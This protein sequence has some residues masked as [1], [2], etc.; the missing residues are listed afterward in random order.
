[1]RRNR[2]VAVLAAVSLLVAVVSLSSRGGGSRTQGAANVVVT[3]RLARLVPA[4]MVV[5]GARPAL[6]WPVQG[7]GAVAVQGIGLMGASSR[8]PIVPIASLTKMMTAYVVLHDHPLAPGEPGPKLVMGPHDVAAYAADVAANNSSVPVRLGERL[9]E[10][11]LLEALLVPSADNIAD[12]LGAW[13]AGSDAAFVVKMNATAR[14]L[15]L[16][17]THYADASGLDPRSR[18]TAADQARLA[19][20][21]MRLPVVRSIVANPSLPFPVAGRVTN[22]NPA[23]GTDG[24]V[25]VKSG[26]TPQAQG[27]LATAAYRVVGGRTV[28]VVAVSLDQ[29]DALYGAARADEALLAGATKSLVAVR[30]A[31]LG[32]ALAAVTTSWA[33]GR[34]VARAGAG[35]A[36]AVG[37]P[38]LHLA[39]QLSALPARG[40]GRG[41]R[42]RSSVVG[43]LTLAAP[44]GPDGAVPLVTVHPLPPVPAGFV[45][46]SS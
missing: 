30:A 31:P 24:I 46:P 2:L 18:S 39:R 20:D 11:Q 34:T 45:P 4:G 3:P 17:H 38:G 15:G 10:L 35:G 16:D 5:P 44:W 32:R 40:A 19:S 6:A 23:L 21:L 42:R 25:G 29:P 41:P 14:A 26:F 22:Y 12:R 13:D 43:A 36:V 7:E 1:M 8:Q 33:S 37:W 28:L 27:C 9:S